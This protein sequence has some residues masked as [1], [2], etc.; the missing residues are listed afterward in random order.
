MANASTKKTAANNVIALKG[1]HTYSLVVN[2]IYVLA[3]LFIRR[4]PTLTPYIICNLPAWGIEY[5]LEKLGRPK[6][7]EN[8]ALLSAGEDLAMKGL[9]EYMWDVV[10]ITWACDCLA[11]V[12][13]SSAAFLLYLTIPAYAIYGAYSTFTASKKR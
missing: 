5:Q 12:T 9:T 1:L 8:G 11:M 7:A 4:P 3:W 10:Y 6:Y 13:G 2:A